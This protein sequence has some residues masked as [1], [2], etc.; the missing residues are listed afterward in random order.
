[1]SN[2]LATGR[3]IF[4]AIGSE[5]ADQVPAADW[6][7]LDPVLPANWRAT[8]PGVSTQTVNRAG[9]PAR[10]VPGQVAWSIGF[11]FPVGSSS[12]RPYLLHLLGSATRS[13]LAAGVFEHTFS[14]AP[15]HPDTTLSAMVGLPPVD[16]NLLYGIRLRQLQITAQPG[17]TV[18][19]RFEGMV[20][21]G[22]R[23]GPSEPQPANTG[24][25]RG[26]WLR[27]PLARPDDGD[28]WVQV[29]RTVAGGGL[30]WKVEQTSGVP[31]WLGAE[32]DVAT[33][34]ESPTVTPWQLVQ[35]ADS[36][37]LGY[38]GENWD[39]LEIA[40]GPLAGL[41]N[42]EVGDTFRLRA[43]TTWT[44]PTL[45]GATPDLVWT[46]PHMLVKTR[47][48]G[49]TGAYYVHER[50]QCQLTIIN[51]V[52]ARSSRPGKYPSLYRPGDTTVQLTFT[53]PYTDAIFE[54]LLE[55]HES[56]DVVVEFIG[57]AQIGSGHRRQLEVRLAACGIPQ[58][59]RQVQNE[60]PVSESITLQMQQPQNA[61]PAITIR[62][63]TSTDWNP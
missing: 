42:L 24:T 54:E 29:T 33:N 45:P 13:V 3:R 11:G 46:H 9:V 48:A 23:V 31:G 7:L 55:Q 17:Q 51:N 39:P 40:W 41:A 19:A 34:P 15:E 50:E 14:L 12:I 27:G 16:R 21:H 4:F 56:L 1:M 62:T 10:T 38:S 2:N 44:A 30:R 26:P 61:D 28:V 57:G 37:D 60:G 43:P 47:P 58:A 22:T 59:Q 63:V 5:L 25:H 35:G 32:I 53:R 49:S 18:Q 36:V 52:V 8:R 6:T 20:G